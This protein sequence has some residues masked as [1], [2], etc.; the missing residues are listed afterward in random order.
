MRARCSGPSIVRMKEGLQRRSDDAL[1]FTHYSASPV[2]PI[3]KFLSKPGDGELQG[4][5]IGNAFPHSWTM[6]AYPASRPS[7]TAAASCRQNLHR[8]QNSSAVARSYDETR[9]HACLCRASRYP[10]AEPKAQS[11][12]QDAPQNAGDAVTQ[13]V[14][15]VESWV[16]ENVRSCA[17]AAR[18]SK[19]R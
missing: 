6:M 8:R 4:P 15:L 9:R 12:P 3:W 10:P 1:G 17:T 2:S 16:A 18:C 13:R 5:G 7:V 11:Q 19:W 14:R